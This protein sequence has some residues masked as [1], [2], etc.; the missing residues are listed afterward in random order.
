[1]NYRDETILVTG[2]TGRQGGA[3]ARH[4]IEDG[5]RVRVFTRDRS[6]PAAQELERLGAEVVRGDLNDSVSVARAVAGC[7]G[8]FSVQD[9]NQA[10]LDGE[11]VQGTTLA[12]AAK[13]ARVK[14]FIYTSVGAADRGTGIPH[15]ETKWRIEERIRAMGLPYTILRPVFFMDNFLSPGLR[16]SIVSG[17]LSLAVRPDRPLQM[18]AVHDIGAIAGRAFADREAFVGR[19][20]DLA[21]DE[22]TLPQACRVLGDA[23]GR[24]VTYE[25]APL[26]EL[27]RS[28]PEFAKMFRWFNEVGYHAD[29]RAVRAV[30]PELLDFRAWATQ[31]FALELMAVA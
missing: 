18:I 27:E 2:A 28:S 5:W 20:L 6:K 25:Q 1:M 13:S 10:G 19:E 16:E 30:L 12:V 31:V 3:A 8:V 24:Q 17:R 4:L 7:H 26:D 15:F 14:H 21:G 29:I 9:F 11:V 23:V 22:L